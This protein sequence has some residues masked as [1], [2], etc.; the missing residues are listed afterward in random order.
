MPQAQGQADPVQAGP[1]TLCVWPLCS[2]V[3]TFRR[4]TKG[5]VGVRSTPGWYHAWHLAVPRAPQNL[6]PWASPALLPRRGSLSATQGLWPKVPDCEWAQS[7]APVAGTPTAE[8]HWQ[9]FS[10]SLPRAT[11]GKVCS[12]LPS[13]V[14]KVSSCASV[15]Q[16]GDSTS[17]DTPALAGP[18]WPR[19]GQGSSPLG[20]PALPSL[21]HL[22]YRMVIVTTGQQQ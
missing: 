20:A 22:Y 19:L 1:D 7:K 12:S 21:P 8:W 5:W 10:A 11:F 6:P 2:H 9:S 4:A 17:Y 15:P 18:H 16:S 14:N 3:L 13:W